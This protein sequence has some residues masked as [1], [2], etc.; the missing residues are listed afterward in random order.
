M[1][2][3]DKVFPFDSKILDGIDANVSS[4]LVCGD[5][6]VLY[7]PVRCDSFINLPFFPPF[8]NQPSSLHWFAFNEK[9]YGSC[10]AGVTWYVDILYIFGFLCRW[11]ICLWLRWNHHKTYDVSLFDNHELMQFS[12]ITQIPYVDRKEHIRIWHFNLGLELDFR[13]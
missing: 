5:F 1:Q 9:M 11:L 6:I 4:Q 10:C 12:N 13:F 3:M 7:W 2:K 8:N